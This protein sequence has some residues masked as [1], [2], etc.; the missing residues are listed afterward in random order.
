MGKAV[1]VRFELI[2]WRVRG[3]A[4]RS[5]GHHRNARPSLGV[6]LLRHSL[7]IGF[8]AYPNRIPPYLEGEKIFQA[9]RRDDNDSS[10]RREE[11]AN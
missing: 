6:L 9:V 1:P 2:E 4:Y 5:A 7:A 11:Y 10:L 3:Y 8:D